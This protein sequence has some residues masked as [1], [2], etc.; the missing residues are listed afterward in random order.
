MDCRSKEISLQFGWN[1]DRFSKF[2]KAVRLNF[3]TLFNNVNI[4]VLRSVQ[5]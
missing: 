3:A 1:L 4:C 2:I 5:K